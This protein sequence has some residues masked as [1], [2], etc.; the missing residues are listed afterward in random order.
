MTLKEVLKAGCDRLQAAG[1]DEARAECEHMLMQLL[2]L[3]RSDTLHRMNLGEALSADQEKQFFAW[4]QAREKRIPLAYLLGD[5]FFH[6]L[7]L[8]VGPGCLIPRSET[9]LLVTKAAAVLREI[10]SPA[11]LDIGCG[12]GAIAL[13][14]L[15]EVKDANAVLVDVSPDA[16]K[17]A[18][19]NAENLKLDKRVKVILSDLFAALTC[20]Q[21]FDLIVSNPPYLTQIDMD[22][23]QPELD[24]EPRQALDGGTDGLDFY[25]RII[26]NA[27]NYLKPG[28]CLGLELGA[29]QSLSVGAMLEKS[30]YTDL[31]VYK[32]HQEIER[33][34]LAVKK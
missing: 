1:I 5:V 14:L 22:A 31:K 26:T 29:G 23:L 34:L 19:A 9:E 30:G 16:L 12:S 25:R 4:I 21:K 13:A 6:G 20:E 28:G 33:T 8:S 11:L 27:G 3:S 17:I 18:R 2:G 7:K 10:K 24:Y 32:D 15:S